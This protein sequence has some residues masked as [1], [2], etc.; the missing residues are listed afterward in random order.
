M[1]RS[2]CLVL[3]LILGLS[4]GCFGPKEE[5]KTEQQEA[6]V[7]VGPIMEEPSVAELEKLGG[8]N[9]IK[10]LDWLQSNGMY[11]VLFESQRFFST[12]IGKE[13]A[14]ILQMVLGNLFML[15]FDLRKV[16]FLAVNGVTRNVTIPPQPGGA[17]VPQVVP[18][19][20]LVYCIRMVAPLDKERFL[21]VFVPPNRGYPAPKLRQVNGKEV[22]DLPAAAPLETHAVVFLNERTILYVL[23]NEATLREV[24]DGNPPTGPLAQRMSRAQMEKSELMLFATAEGSP[25]FPP[26]A[27]G[28]FAKAFNISEGL[29]RTLLE[30]FKALQL[31]LN[32]GAVEKENLVKVDFYTP[33]AEGA[34]EVV[35]KLTEQVMVMRTSSGESEQPTGQGLGMIDPQL[36]G[37]LT[38]NVDPAV[39]D[40]L[41]MT[42][43]DSVAQIDLQWFSDFSGMMKQFFEEQRATIRSI[44]Q[45]QQL[46]AIM[47]QVIRRL[48]AI[49]EY[50]MMYH[51]EKGEFPS[52]I[53]DREGNPLLSWR[54]ALLPYMGPNERNIHG[55]FK[56]DESWDS[57]HNKGLIDKM[58]A[59]FSDPRG[60]FDPTKTTFQ[61]FDSGG[62]PFARSP[63]KMSDLVN[64]SGT[65]MIFAVSPKNAV[66]W[67]R[68][69]N[70]TLE[71]QTVATLAELFGPIVPIVSFAG[72]PG[73]LPWVN[74]SEFFD[75]FLKLVKGE[76]VPQ[77]VSPQTPSEAPGL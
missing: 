13:G 47:E 23:S 36:I 40:A 67:T 5:E 12:D 9:Q 69:E 7:S 59:L 14:D 21:S 72:Q 51:A 57:P 42:S 77:A 29:A 30:N 46:Q 52:T 28:V 64:P 4:S 11:G 24:L 60:A 61:L 20:S 27:V 65:P 16:E 49:R 76:P 62:T 35:K 8:K 25:L 71:E 63:L 53:R 3:L 54:V 56:L 48:L 68:P 44:Q 75:V 55:Q 32:L 34:K 74:R 43:S 22:Y 6:A 45:E 2:L 33:T 31:S 10:E 50:M 26:D 38:Q 15:P 39:L 18:L 66:E 70:L 41:E 73:V 1:K 58:P 19:P 37:M 17:D